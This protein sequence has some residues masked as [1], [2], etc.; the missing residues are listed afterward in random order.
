MTDIH[1]IKMKRGNPNLRGRPPGAH[2]QRL[3]FLEKKWLYDT[4][5]SHSKVL[6][7][8]GEGGR[9]L[10]DYHPEWDDDRV[11]E[12]AQKKFGR[13]LSKFVVATF[14][15]KNLGTLRGGP[16]S[17]GLL[18]PHTKSP[19]LIAAQLAHM[20][21]ALEAIE[22]RVASMEEFNAQ[23]GYRIP[24]IVADDIEEPVHVQ[25]AK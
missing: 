23:Q 25:A 17:G 21:R 19:T 10:I 16:R 4:I 6:P 22:L 1:D 8:T 18:H 15:T 12:E 5:F 14:R 24:E 7:G 20:R 13:A 3:T 11:R 2:G 9:N